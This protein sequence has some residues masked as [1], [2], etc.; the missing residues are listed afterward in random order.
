MF[1]FENIFNFIMLSRDSLYPAMSR[2]KSII[3]RDL[4]LSKWI[5]ERSLHSKK[6]TGY[7]TL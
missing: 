5:N 4:F 2:E 3:T 7:V 6:V 1:T